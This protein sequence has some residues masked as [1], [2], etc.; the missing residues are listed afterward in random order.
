MIVYFIIISWLLVDFLS[1][2]IALYNLS[3][4]INLI[5]ELMKLRLT[6]NTGIAFS[7]PLSWIFLKIITIA[8]IIAISFFYVKYEREKKLKILDIAYSLILAWAIWNGIDR[9][10]NGSVIDF[11]S[12]KYF[13][14]FNFADIFI[15][16]WMLLLLFYY[17]QI[18]WKNKK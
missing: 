5:W 10:I 17:L 9:V 12:V 13:A 2:K 16:I 7:L 1:K 15:N 6:H 4:D 3:Q 11:I 18:S 14:I 8:L